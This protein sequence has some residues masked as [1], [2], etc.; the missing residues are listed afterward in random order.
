MITA[1]VGLGNILRR[2]EGIGVFLL[3]EIR[4]NKE[5]KKFGNIEFIDGGTAS[6]D[7]M[8]NITAGDRLIVMDAV[9][10]GGEPGDVHF[11][12]PGDLSEDGMIDVHQAGL[13]RSLKWLE[14][15]GRLPDVSIL[16]IEI[17]DISWS[18]GLSDGLL[19][20]VP[21]IKEKVISEIIRIMNGEKSV[22]A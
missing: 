15:E 16:G 19:G 9:K 4:K 8:S 18:E 17:D 13:C 6:F 10:S 21:R 14:M 7:A 22:T 1:V 2:D 3:K 20:K 5:L 11:L 12:K